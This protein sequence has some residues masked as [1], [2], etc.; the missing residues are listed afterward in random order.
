MLL[1]RIKNN[2]VL[3]MYN[4][5]ENFPMIYRYCLCIINPSNHL[6]YRRKIT[7]TT[8][9]NFHRYSRTS[10]LFSRIHIPVCNMGGWCEENSVYIKYT[11]NWIQGVMKILLI[12][13]FR[14]KINFTTLSTLHKWSVGIYTGLY[15]QQFSFR[16]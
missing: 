6:K 14:N 1:R 8:T 13:Y 2:D 11:Q 16:V 9:A 4:I 3:G 15:T 12:I 5:R 7:Q 10:I